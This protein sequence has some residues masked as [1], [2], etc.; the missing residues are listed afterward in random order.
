MSKLANALHYYKPPFCTFFFCSYCYHW[1]HSHTWNNH[2]FIPCFT[3]FLSLYLSLL[4]PSCLHTN[5][6][7]VHLKQKQKTLKSFVPHFACLCRCLVCCVHVRVSV[8][9]Y[10]YHIPVI[11]YLY[12]HFF[13]SNKFFLY[14][15][16]IMCDRIHYALTCIS[17]ASICQ[18]KNAHLNI[19]VRKAKHN[20]WEADTVIWYTNET[21]Y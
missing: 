14:V 4:T 6:V 18:P 5:D 15:D 1:H 9:V 10:L 11:F 7:I 3:L 8:S 21:P 2:H 12:H 19:C 13:L 16:C 20:K 17:I